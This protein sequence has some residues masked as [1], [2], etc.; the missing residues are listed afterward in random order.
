MRLKDGG[1]LNDLG[2]ALAFAAVFIAILGV[3]AAI[4]LPLGIHSAH[5]SCL[6]LSEQTGLATRY[7]R[8]GVEGECYVQVGGKWIPEDRWRAIDE[9]S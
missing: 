6:R 3:M 2:F 5:V 1:G 9:S 7:A 4:V 8:S